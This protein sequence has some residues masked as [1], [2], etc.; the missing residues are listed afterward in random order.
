MWCKIIPFYLINGK[1]NVTYETENYF[2]SKE[3]I[4]YFTT[5]NNI[6]KLIHL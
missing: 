3:E 6:S 5:H 4:K 1:V 2:K